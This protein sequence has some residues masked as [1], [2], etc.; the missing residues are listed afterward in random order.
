MF[1]QLNGQ[2]FLRKMIVPALLTSSLPVF[3]QDFTGY[4]TGNYTG[5]NGVFFNPANIADS[6]YRWDVNLFSVSVLAGNNQ[7]SFKLSK[8]GDS[9]NADSLEN[10]LYGKNAGGTSGAMNVGFLAPSFL[11]NVS[12]KT[13]IA[14]TSRARVMANV[15]DIDGTL[16]QQVVDGYTSDAGLPYSITSG[17]NMFVNMNAWAEFGASVGQV[18]YDGD[19]HF[20][21]GGLT[22]K[23]LAGVANN[24]IQLKN[25]AATINEDKASSRAYLSNTTGRIGIGFGG[26]SFDD[27]EASNLTKFE[28]SGFGFDLGFVYEFRPDHAKHRT[29]DNYGWKRNENKYKLRVG[30]ALLDIGSIR[31]KRD[32]SRSAAYDLGV[33]GSERYYLSELNDVDLDDY[34]QH[35]DSRPQFFTPVA[36]SAENEYKVALPTT[37]Q[38][39]VDYNIHNGFYVSAAGQFSLVSS[40]NKPYNSQYQNAFTV[41]PRYESRL[42]SAFLPLNYNELTKF[43]AGISVRFGPVFIGSGS[44]ITALLDESKQLDAHIGVRFGVLHKNKAGKKKVKKEKA[45]EETK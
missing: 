19:K 23:Y 38:L 30:V 14:L 37:I 17:K 43:N 8:I 13:S 3:S 42:F 5:V 9:F 31:Y 29:S 27:F 20:L 36:G 6:R 18:L 26:N 4:R 1:K 41:T 33:T 2:S 39:D 35:F 45:A 34:K 32:L 16:L 10:Q 22:L 28:S 11:F 15:Q 7:A 25:F 40:D 12:P 24:Y 44:A 21:K